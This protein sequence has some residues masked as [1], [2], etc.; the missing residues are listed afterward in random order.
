MRLQHRVFPGGWE[1][2]VRAW[3]GPVTPE[4]SVK[5]VSSLCP[6]VAGVVSHC[7][8]VPILSSYRN[9]RL[10]QGPP[11]WPHFTS[12]FSLKALSPVKF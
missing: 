4:A 3:A 12:I 6:H 2:R 8:R 9:D 10:D 11:R 7:A 5:A 1:S